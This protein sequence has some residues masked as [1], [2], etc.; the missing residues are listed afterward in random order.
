MSTARFFWTLPTNVIGHA[1]GLVVTRSWP[2]RIGSQAA[3]GW[4]YLLPPSWNNVFG[5]VA[6]GDA[7]ISTPNLLRGER[8]RLVLAHELSHVGQ[9]SWL[10][11]FYLPLH[12]LAQIGSVV[13]SLVRPKPGGS[14]IHSYNP[15]E[16][17]FLSFP[18]D[19]IK[20]SD[21]KRSERIEQ[22]LASF[23]V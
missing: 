18:Y 5:A 17:R 12:A 8:G 2:V 4:L 1:V 16:Q 23:G 9:H 6:L 13:T 7:V 15:L 3:P 10:G 20:N 22:L 11:P 14:R 19:E 21:V